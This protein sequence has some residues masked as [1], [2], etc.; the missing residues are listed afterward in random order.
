[1]NKKKKQTK[2]EWE[3]NVAT[4]THIEYIIKTIP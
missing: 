1:M 4:D 3:K 2:I